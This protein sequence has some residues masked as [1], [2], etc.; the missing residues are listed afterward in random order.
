[1]TLHFRR[2]VAIVMAEYISQVKNKSMKDLN[3]IEFENF[4]DTLKKPR[5]T[6]S[7]LVR[8]I[9]VVL[10]GQCNVDDAATNVVAM[11]IRRKHPL[12]STLFQQANV[13]IR[14][15]QMEGSHLYPNYKKIIVEKWFILDTE[16]IPSEKTIE[17]MKLIIEK[18]GNPKNPS[19]KKWTYLAINFKGLPS[20]SENCK[21]QESRKRFKD[22]VNHCD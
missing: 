2:L 16:I 7:R 14:E 3:L 9:L 8:D 6:I 1:M 12:S 20:N 11:W 15:R 13:S 19:E 22:I 10:C 17:E 5:A 21:F 18:Y 4:L